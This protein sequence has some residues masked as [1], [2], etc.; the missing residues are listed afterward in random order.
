MG[1]TIEVYAAE[2]Q[3]LGAIFS[4]LLA[5]VSSEDRADEEE[6]LFDRLDT[7]PKALF[8]SRLLLPDDLDHLCTLFTSYRPGLPSH[9][10][11]ICMKELWNDGAGTESLTLLSEEFVSE[12]ASLQE[13]EIQRVARDWAA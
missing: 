9:F 5:I 2:P 8:P 7:Y 13:Q 4:Q 10:Q 11:A 1:L 3:E 12:I 6:L